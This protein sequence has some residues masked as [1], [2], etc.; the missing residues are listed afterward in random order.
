M[1]ARSASQDGEPQLLMA[2]EHGFRPLS[3]E[4]GAPSWTPAD[5]GSRGLQ[6][7]LRGAV[8]ASWVGSIPIH[9]AKP[10]SALAISRGIHNHYADL[11]ARPQ[12][13]R[14]VTRSFT[15]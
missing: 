15:R 2:H 3:F 10:G 11:T 14:Q 13:L 9:P 1:T 7:C 5:A 12:I 4:V 6:N 8:E